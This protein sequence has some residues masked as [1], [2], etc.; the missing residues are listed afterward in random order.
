MPFLQQV[1]VASLY[2]DSGELRRMT[3]GV[4]NLA[5]SLEAALYDRCDSFLVVGAGHLHG[6]SGWHGKR[7][8]EQGA[9]AFCAIGA[10]VPNHTFRTSVPRV[11]LAPRN[12][13]REHC[14]A[15]HKG[16]PNPQPIQ[17]DRYFDET[18][19]T[20][21]SPLQHRVSACG[22][23]RSRRSR[24][25][26]HWEHPKL[27]LREEEIPF[28]RPRCPPVRCRERWMFPGRRS[29]L[30]SLQRELTP[31]CGQ[32]AAACSSLR[33]SSRAATIVALPRPSPIRRALQTICRQRLVRPLG[34]W[35]V[36]REIS[37]GRWV[38]TSLVAGG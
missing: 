20:H 4:G 33:M 26:R 5:E 24:Q 17:A 37:R 7:Q 32:D 36:H 30:R 10:F 3:G 13:P 2:K 27:S 31:R 34:L 18:E 22:R 11:R 12:L 8:D 16:S 23:R 21:L 15:V 28:L 38:H 35:S 14:I 1:V 9:S 6:A 29:G 19:L 25:L